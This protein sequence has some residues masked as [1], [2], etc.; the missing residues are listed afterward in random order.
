[1]HIRSYQE[2]D[3]P[4]VLALLEKNIPRYFAP[5]EWEDLRR[6]QESE[7]EVYFVLEVEKV[8]IGAGGIN[9]FPSEKKA[10]ISWDFL[11]PDWQ[12]QGLG[13]RL[14][15]YRLEWIRQREEYDWIEVRTSQFAFRFYEQAGFRVQE[16]KKDH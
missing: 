4:A 14:L 2:A 8:L 13:S 9:F 16:I 15:A 3:Q 12:G 5:E 6:Y 11:D 1:M 10:R 7:R